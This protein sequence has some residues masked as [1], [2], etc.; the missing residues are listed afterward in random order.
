MRGQQPNSGTSKKR[1]TAV[2][3]L[4]AFVDHRVEMAEAELGIGPEVVPLAQRGSRGL[5]RMACCTSD[6]ACSNWRKYAN[7]MER[8]N[9]RSPVR[10]TPGTTAFPFDRKG[11]LVAKC[12]KV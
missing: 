1:D 9:R 4:V 6:F 2:D 7:G 10:E 12:Q 11:R 5:R 8:G 3:C